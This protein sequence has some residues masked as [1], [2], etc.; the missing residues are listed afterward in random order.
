LPADPLTVQNPFDNSY[1]LGGYVLAIETSSGSWIDV[2][3]AARVLAGL[4]DTFAETLWYKLWGHDTFDEEQHQPV[5]FEE[6]S[7]VEGVHGLPVPRTL[8]RAFTA[9][10]GSGPRLIQGLTTTDVSIADDTFGIVVVIPLAGGTDPSAGNPATVIQVANMHLGAYP[11]GHPIVAAYVATPINGCDWVTI[12]FDDFRLIRGIAVN[13]VAETDMSFAIRTVTQMA[14]GASPV[15]APLDQV[16]VANQ[17]RG[18]YAQGENVIAIYD[19][20]LLFA[21]PALPPWLAI[22]LGGSTSGP[23]TVLIP[24]VN[25]EQNAIEAATRVGP[26]PII[27]PEL[28]DLT[29][30]EFDLNTARFE[31]GDQEITCY[32][33]DGEAIANPPNGYVLLGEV[34]PFATNNAGD[35]LYKIIAVYCTRWE[36]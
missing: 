32:Y 13:A 27:Q 5:Y 35:Q 6:F 19:P 7:A 23:I 26:G 20:S 14:G 31:P 9:A 25:G 21:V 16:L 29:V 2:P 24:R 18:K 11:S 34:L 22:P 33:L 3:Y 36:D 17:A 15:L 8:V 10:G 12:D 28:L 4:G 30:M 1:P